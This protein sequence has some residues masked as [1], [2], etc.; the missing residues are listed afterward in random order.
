M[1]LPFPQGGLELLRIKLAFPH[2]RRGLNCLREKFL[3]KNKFPNVSQENVRD[4][5]CSN[6]IFIISFESF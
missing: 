4:K 6:Q 2:R 3:L 1:E 5:L